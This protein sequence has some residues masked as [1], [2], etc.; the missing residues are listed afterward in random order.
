[1]IITPRVLIIEDEAHL[2]R[3][4]AKV[5]TYAGYEVHQAANLSRAAD[6]IYEYPFDVIVCDIEVGDERSFDLLDRYFDVLE[7]NST[8]LLIISGDE[9]YRQVAQ[10]VGFDFFMSKPIAIEALVKMVE[11]LVM[12]LDQVE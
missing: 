3:M 1:M 6:L 10:D 9:R 2:L 8:Q 7:E 11:R 4:Y 12:T 5:L